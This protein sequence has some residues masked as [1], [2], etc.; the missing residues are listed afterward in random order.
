MTN[1]QTTD[2]N[3]T[4]YNRT[5][6][7]VTVIVGTFTTVLTQTLLAT[8]YPT[9]MK[10]FDISTSTVQWLTTGFLLVNGIMIP[11]S[12]FLINR[13]NSKYLYIGAMGVFFIGTLICFIAPNFSVLLIGRLIEAVGVGLSMPL[14]QTISL[15][16]FPPEKRGAA[17]GMAG[18][19]IGLAPAIG[20]TLSG[21]VID[22]YDWRALFGM[23]LPIAGLVII[24]SFFFM[25]KVLRTSKPDLDVLSVILSTIG[26]GSLLYG[27][28]EVGDK[29]WGSPLVLGLLVIGVVFIFLF[30]RRQLHLEH[31]FLELRVFTN[32]TFTV[33][34][35]LSSV[36]NMAMVGVEMVLPLYL[37]TVRGESAFHSGLTL[38]PG[39]LMMG[40][41][42]PIT[43]QLFDRIG[44]KRL[45]ITGMTLLTLGT[46][47]FA[48][49]TKDTPLAEVVIL[50]AVR[51]FGI[52]MVMMPV[53]TAGMNAL[54]FDLI[55]HGTAVNNT[56]R[57]V[58]SSVGTAILISILSNVTNAQMPG[59]H[60]LK[61]APLQY[62]DNALTSV[63]S[64]YRAA[65]L[66]AV[67]FCVIGLIVS[68]FLK[69]TDSKE[70]VQR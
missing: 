20:P 2:V 18:L 64:G 7:L 65:F 50:Y 23:I 38:L 12:A 34:A 28:S 47:S 37:Q 22:N 42:S 59:K 43:G 21:W 57:Q 8:A 33:S 16:I 53:T 70:E 11:I 9:L 44:A 32:H 10:T 3:G 49:I 15:S 52:S 54:S 19:A 6:L 48:F 27:F 14:M 51:L 56:T 61:T 60:L 41:M 5:L 45:A 30:G 17:M 26:F 40:I 62:K 69:N 67:I 24:A 31:P 58:A 63:L 13:F 1:T 46:L 36:V 66:V 29:G 68:F 39:A 25:R 55:S 4:P 35:I